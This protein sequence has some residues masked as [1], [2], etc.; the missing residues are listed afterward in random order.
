MSCRFFLC[1]AALAFAS[2]AHAQRGGADWDKTERARWRTVQRVLDQTQKAR[3]NARVQEIAPRADGKLRVR[4]LGE[5]QQAYAITWE[6]PSRPMPWVQGDRVALGLRRGQVILAEPS[7]MHL[8]F[9]R[10]GAGGEVEVLASSAGRFYLLRPNWLGEARRFAM[11]TRWVRG[12]GLVLANQIAS[13]SP[14]FADAPRVPGSGI[15]PVN[16]PAQR[17]LP[18][19]DGWLKDNGFWEKGPPP[20]AAKPDN[21]PLR[22]MRELIPPRQR[23]FSAG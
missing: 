1:A 4:F 16:A 7:D 23:V 5:D 3:R 19:R 14:D 2:L 9:F 21:A 15:I 10:R 20:P 17:T 18:E 11:E 22:R 13:N 8:E 6:D 12:V